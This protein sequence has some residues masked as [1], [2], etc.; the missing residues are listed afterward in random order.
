MLRRVQSREQPHRGLADL[1]AWRVAERD[2]EVASGLGGDAARA[3]PAAAHDAGEQLE[4]GVAGLGV[5][6]LCVAGLVIRSL[7]RP[8]WISLLVGLLTACY[9][10]LRTYRPNAACWLLLLGSGRS[11]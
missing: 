9:L 1:L 11:A 7:L 2:D 5:A 6:G 10:L 3:E 8:R 4:P